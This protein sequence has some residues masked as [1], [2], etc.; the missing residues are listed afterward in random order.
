LLRT[1]RTVEGVGELACAGMEMRV[2]EVD[3][4]VVTRAVDNRTK[5]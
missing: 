5:D 4:D 1:W 3:Q 2:T